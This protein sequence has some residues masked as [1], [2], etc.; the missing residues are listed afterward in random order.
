LLRLIEEEEN[1]FIRTLQQ[2]RGLFEETVAQKKKSGAT[3]ISGDEAFKLWDTFGFPVE[4]TVELAQS[5][6]LQVDMPG[7]KKAME[8]AAEISQAGSAMAKEIFASGPVAELKQKY[9]G[10]A[11]E[12]LGYDNL[13]IDG[14][15]ILAVVQKNTLTEKAQSGDEALVL[16]EKSPF[17]AESGGQVG[18]RGY[19]I[20]GGRKH[21]V[22]D[23]KKDEGLFLHRVKIDGELKT[24]EAVEAV[25]DA[26]HRN[27]T[28]KNHSA[29]HLLHYVLRRV[30]GKH[31]EQKGSLV[32]PDRLRFDFTHFEPIKPELLIEIEERVNALITAD[33]PVDTKVM[34][35]AE[36]K[37]TGAMALFGEKY[38]DK[39]RVVTM[40][41]SVEL[42]GGTHC[43]TTGQIGY[44]RLV[45][46]SSVAAGVR[47]IEALTGAAAVQDA[48]RSEE[49]LNKLAQSLKTRKE[50]IHERIAALQEE[51]SAAERELES[52]RRKAASATAGELLS[53]VQDV[54]GA[55]LL[56][57]AVPGADAAALRTTLD[58]VRKTLKE[59]AVVLGGSKDGKAALLVSFSPEIVTRGGHAGNL[60][61]ELAPKVGGKGGGKP[62]MA[63]GGGSDP[64]KL[65]EA[66][67]A[68]AGLLATMLK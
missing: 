20:V 65:P 51:K 33:S 2:G 31:V 22:L 42:C 39:V 5:A 44:F 18:D 21:E 49:L 57:A 23:T 34:P 28:I 68:A 8:K 67:A 50:T 36:A 52:L 27:P 16:L 24:G 1:A 38:G 7:F 11:T 45:S 54:A 61:K 32:A 9:A 48:R 56:A 41:P 46:E 4:L 13:R 37:A 47:R 14:A 63:Q 64:A 19:L 26:Q 66:L 60:L 55:K 62:E 6:G 30:L 58:G 40:G 3:L 43:Q 53:Q 25:V 17:Y 15:K 35:I 12:F 29:T 59:G 10:R